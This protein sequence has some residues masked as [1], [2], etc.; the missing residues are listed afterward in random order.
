MLIY[1]VEWVFIY[2]S[3]VFFVIKCVFYFKFFLMSVV[4]L[5]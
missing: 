2:V 1:F 5:K 3:C 4:F